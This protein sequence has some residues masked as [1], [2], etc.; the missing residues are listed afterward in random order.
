MVAQCL[1]TNE[2]GKPCEAQPVRRSGYCFWHDPALADE[3]DRKRREG[4]VNRSNK[5]RA[6]KAL[7]ADPLS[8][9]EVRSYLGVV[10]LDV[11]SGKV[12]PGVGTAA[13]N[14]ARALMDV[15]KVAEV[16]QQVAELRRDMA[17]FSE[18]RGI[19]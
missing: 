11:I 3:R 19:S 15:A 5:A 17:A 18:R 9:E 4:G 10:F 8:A 1:G 12:E 2:K 6:R 7:P 14:I 16:E 13:A